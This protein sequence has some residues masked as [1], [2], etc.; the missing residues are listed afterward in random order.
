MNNPETTKAVDSLP[1]E[2]L[3]TFRRHEARLDRAESVA[4]AGHIDSSHESYRPLRRTAYSHRQ[5]AR[6]VFAGQM[7]DGIG[8]GS[9]I[10]LD[11][12]NCAIPERPM[13]PAD[14]PIRR[15][16]RVG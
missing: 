14:K 8:P 13:P 11:P 16:K 5:P 6:Q 15:M 9:G 4:P 7:T 10:L 2:E 12:D 1:P 3:V